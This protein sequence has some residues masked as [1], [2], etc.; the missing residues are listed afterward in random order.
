V[1][2][3]AKET[4]LRAEDLYDLPDDANHY[5]LRRG[6]LVSEPP[7]GG[8][9]GRL[10]ARLVIELGAYARRTGAGIVLTAEAGFI[11][12]RDPDTVLAPD[13]AFMTMARYGAL[14]DESKFIP[15]PPDL[16]V[17]VRSP[18]ER[19]KD[20]NEKVA[21]YLEAATQVVWVC[22]PAEQTVRVYPPASGATLCRG[23]VLRAPELLPGFELA[24]GEVFRPVT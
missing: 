21:S 20:I 15:G 12:E 5:E 4:R 3:P 8:R 18:S 17:E 7:S 1:N 9:H 13:V 22:D 10:S 11:L 16:A 23:D 19:I 14:E 24:I 2:N 6:C